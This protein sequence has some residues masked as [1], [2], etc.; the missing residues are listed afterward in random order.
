MPIHSAGLD[1]RGTSLF[2]D[3]DAPSATL[4]AMLVVPFLVVCLAGVVTVLAVA[5]RAVA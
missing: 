1:V 2:D 3:T 4:I 5:G